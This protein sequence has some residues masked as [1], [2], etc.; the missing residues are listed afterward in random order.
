M[1]RR[2]WYYLVF[3]QLLSIPCFA[4][5]SGYKEYLDQ[6]KDLVNE[7]TWADGV[8]DAFSSA[9]KG[10]AKHPE[11][12]QANALLSGVGGGLKGAANEQR[13]SETK[14]IEEAVR[15][16]AELALQLEEQ[17]LTIALKELAQKQQKSKQHK[18]YPQSK[19]N[20]EQEAFFII[21]YDKKG[22]TYCTKSKK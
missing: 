6:Y 16:N 7:P 14:V 9:G 17:R 4:M 12:H 22:K 1:M 3:C 10:S 2:Y 21:C 19:E 13:R 18:K 5:K 20:Q 11:D 8:G 15:R